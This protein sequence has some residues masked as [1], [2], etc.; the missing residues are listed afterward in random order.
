[1]ETLFYYIEPV[2][3]I[4]LAKLISN[5]WVH[6][7]LS[8]DENRYEIKRV[9][10]NKIVKAAKEQLRPWPIDW[11]LSVDMNDLLDMLESKGNDE[12]KN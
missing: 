9:G 4:L 3:S 2:K 5:L 6:S 12:G 8:I 11:S 1:M 7:K 10:K